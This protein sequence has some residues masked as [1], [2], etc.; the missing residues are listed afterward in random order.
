M[1]TGPQARALENRQREEQIALAKSNPL[2]FKTMPSWYTPSAS[3]NAVKNEKAVTPTKTTTPSKPVTQSNA[4]VEAEMKK[5]GLL[6][7]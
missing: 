2:D 5:R 3:E 7:P 6:P 4:S 1:L